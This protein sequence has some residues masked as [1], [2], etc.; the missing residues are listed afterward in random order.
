MPAHIGVAALVPRTAGRRALVDDGHAAA[1]G[2]RRDVRLVAR[3]SSGVTPI[4]YAGLSSDSLG[5]RRR[6]RSTRVSGRRRRDVVPPTPTTYGLD[7]GQPAEMILL[8]VP[9][10]QPSVPVSPEAK[11]HCCP[12]AC[13]CANSAFMTGISP[14]EPRSQ[15]P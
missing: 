4:W 5:R 1:A 7:A 14:A 3:V 10:R 11:N 8:P 6:R 13:A 9:S 12:S 15:L 2:D